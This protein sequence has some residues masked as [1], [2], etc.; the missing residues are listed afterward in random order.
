MKLSREKVER[1]QSKKIAVLQQ[2]DLNQRRKAK[3]LARCDKGKRCHLPEC[4]RCKQRKA[5]AHKRT[6]KPTKT[7]I[8]SKLVLR[9]QQ[10]KGF[11]IPQPSFWGAHPNRVSQQLGADRW[12][13]PDWSILDGRRGE[14]PDFSLDTLGQPLRDCLERVS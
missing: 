2:G 1:R 8:K 11:L 5:R 13:D 7:A 14:L 3:A 12:L 10:R 9:P 4:E 6:S